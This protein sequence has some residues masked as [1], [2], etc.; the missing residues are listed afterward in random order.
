MQTYH[1][2]SFSVI[3]TIRVVVKKML[4]SIDYDQE[5]I[6]Y[7]IAPA[8]KS[9]DPLCV[10]VA[11][12]ENVRI[13]LM[14]SRRKFEIGDVV[15]GAAHFLLVN[16]KIKSFTVSVMAQELT[17]VSG[18]TKKHKQY[19]GTWEVCDGAPVKGEIVPFRIFFAPLGLSPSCSRA[20]SGYTVT[21]FLHFL[22]VTT[23]NEKYFKSLQIKL[24]K[25][26]TLPFTF[27]D[28]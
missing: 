6:S 28:E 14:I 17:E 18:K 12:A 11:V 15:Y 7:A 4:G 2:G 1:G 10:R 23:S 13:D 9:L 21:H 22:I 24:Y 8:I 20:E 3:H 25:C 19:W 27:T 26:S 5:I 16:L